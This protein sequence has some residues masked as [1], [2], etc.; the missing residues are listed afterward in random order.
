M[1]NTIDRHPIHLVGQGIYSD[2]KLLKKCG[3][4]VD[5]HRTDA[6]DLIQ[7]RYVATDAKIVSKE[8]GP[9]SSR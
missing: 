3:R 1:D 5:L 6:V 4:K 7:A 9:P 8:T 2:V